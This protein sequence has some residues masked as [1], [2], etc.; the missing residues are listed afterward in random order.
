MILAAG[1][2]VGLWSSR[3]LCIFCRETTATAAFR[4]HSVEDRGGSRSIGPRRTRFLTWCVFPNFGYKFLSQSHSSDCDPQGTVTYLGCPF[5]RI[6][7]LTLKRPAKV[8]ARESLVSALVS[9]LPTCAT[10]PRRSHPMR[11]VRRRAPIER[12]LT[13][14][15]PQGFLGSLLL[16]VS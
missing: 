8:R 12:P 10:T 15:L 11:E 1:I 13:P 5:K 14:I 7:S 6:D 16:A 9:K 3:C 2:L 4:R